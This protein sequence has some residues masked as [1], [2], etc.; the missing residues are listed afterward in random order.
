MSMPGKFWCSVMW[1]VCTEYTNTVYLLQSHIII[2]D[3]L[4]LR[5][6]SYLDFTI[7]AT[8]DR[9]KD[10]IYLG[11]LTWISPLSTSSCWN[12]GI[13][14]S[15][16][17]EDW[18][19]WV[20]AGAVWLTFSHQPRWQGKCQTHLQWS[21]SPPLNWSWAHHVDRASCFRPRTRAQHEVCTGVQAGNNMDYRGHFNG[22]W[23]ELIGAPSPLPRLRCVHNA[24]SQRNCY[25]M[26]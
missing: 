25:F 22:V 15:R 2:L 16:I 7:H 10:K 13:T 1:N 24:G 26:S 9:T 3:N 20:G 19:C 23:R 17:E 18:V 12:R 11:I 6:A 14:L 4:D 21:Q 8:P 5:H